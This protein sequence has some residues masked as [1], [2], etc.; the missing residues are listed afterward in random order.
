M[1][2]EEIQRRV[3]P[4]RSARIPQRWAAKKASVC[5]A[6]IC[7]QTLGESQRESWA[8]GLPSGGCMVNFQ[9]WSAPS[10]QAIR[11]LVI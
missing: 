4:Q 6:R 2:R 9:L 7:S 10:A 11:Q 3:S 1:G 5:E 8:G